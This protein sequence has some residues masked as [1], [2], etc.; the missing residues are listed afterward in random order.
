[1]VLL[2]AVDSHWMDHI[3]AMD[4]LRQGIGLQ[5][6]GQQDPVVAYRN[7]GFDMFDDMVA[8]IREQTVRGVFHVTLQAAPQKRVQLAKPIEVSGDSKRS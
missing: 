5:A 8:G 3:D 4:Q 1:M 7:A 2:R 6:I